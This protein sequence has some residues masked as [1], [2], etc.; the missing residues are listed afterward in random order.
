[1]GNKTP[2]TPKRM[3]QLSRNGEIDLQSFNMLAM[4][5]QKITKS[6]L[7]EIPKLITPKTN[8]V[9]VKAKELSKA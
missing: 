2:T 3:N 9:P 6:G 7:T 4:T 8:F 5:N 1:M